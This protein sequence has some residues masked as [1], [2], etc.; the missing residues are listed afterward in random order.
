M[1]SKNVS[2]SAVMAVLLSAPAAAFMP[3]SRPSHSAVRK[4][5]L[6]MS[7]ALIVQN[8]GGGHGELG[9]L[10]ISYPRPGH[11]CFTINITSLLTV[12]M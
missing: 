4:S 1:M 2:F 7:A 3:S 6:S 11:L 9:T 10:F 5:S 12:L 8:K